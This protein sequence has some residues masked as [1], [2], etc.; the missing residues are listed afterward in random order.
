MV[1]AHAAKIKNTKQMLKKMWAS[2][3]GREENFGGETTYFK[4]F[5]NL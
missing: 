2:C 1:A 4:L 3:Y 5:S